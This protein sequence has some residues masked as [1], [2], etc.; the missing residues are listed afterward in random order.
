MESNELL[1]RV[2]KNIESVEEDPS[3][4]LDV[5][6]FE[7]AELVFPKT[8]LSADAQLGLIQKLTTLLPNLQQDATPVI[9]L[10]LRFLEDFTYSDIL[11]IASQGLPFTDGLAVEEH[12]V[13]YNR[14]VLTLL[15]KA[16]RKPADAAHVASMLDT[17]ACSGQIMALH[18]RY[19]NCKSGIKAPLR[20]FESRSRDTSRRRC[21]RSRRR[22]RL[23]METDIR[24]SKYLRYHLRG[25]L[26]D[27]TFDDQ[28]E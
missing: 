2:I 3:I 20:S 25:L 28:I 19:R 15:E 4:P 11:S 22:A 14:L 9:N 8:G 12:M 5:R 6:T 16:T 1:S 27:W 13:S 18:E 21:S 23:G 26:I 10:L 7:E 24:R 17:N